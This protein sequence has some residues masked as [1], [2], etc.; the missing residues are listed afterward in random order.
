M[1]HVVDSKSQPVQSDMKLRVDDRCRAQNQPH[2]VRPSHISYQQGKETDAVLAG[3]S[4]G[5]SIPCG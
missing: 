2:Y 4:A 3:I 5:A 1:S